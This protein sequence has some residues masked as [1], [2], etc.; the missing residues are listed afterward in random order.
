MKIRTLADIE[1]FEQVPA[2]ERW[3]GQNTY[4][5]IERSAHRHAE[6]PALQF[7]ASSDVG[8]E[9]TVIRYGELLKRIHQFAN[10]LYD[11]GLSPGA[12][13]SVIMPNQLETHFAL[14]GA[15]AFGIV[16]PINPMLESQGLRD[17]M[18]E[19]GSECLVVLGPTEA[20]NT[21]HKTMAI[22]DQIPSLKL[23]LRVDSASDRVADDATPGGIPVR[24]MMPAL[25]QASGSGLAFKREIAPESIAA[26]F[27]T[28]GT[29]GT[30]KLA[31]HTHANQVHLSSM[32]ADYFSFDEDTVAIAGLPLFHVNAFFNTGL[33][34]FACGGAAAMLTS[35]GFR[36][37]GVVSNLWRFVEKY[38]ARFF[39]TVP[40]V[41]SSLLE[42]PPGD[43]D[44]SSLNWI[45]C[46][47]APIAPQVF[48]DFQQA[49]GVN[50][51]EGYGLTEATLFS[52][53]NPEH[54]QKK[55]GSIGIRVPYQ[56][57]KCVILDDQGSY[58][59]DCEIDEA[60]VIVVR[61]PNVFPG[62]KQQEKNKAAFIDD[63]LITGDLARQDADGYFWMTG[64][65][66]DLIIRGGH[67]IDPKSIEDA[68]S[69]HPSVAL[70]GAIGQ[71]DSYAGEL[72]CAYVTLV[73]GAQDGAEDL[74]IYAKEKIAERAA[75]PV[76]IE[77]LEDMPVTAVGKIYKPDLRKLAIVRVYENSL[78]E[79]APTTKIEVIDDK[80]RGLV[81]VIECFDANDTTLE[82]IRNVLGQFAIDFELHRKL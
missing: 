78:R 38:R 56:A 25:E 44:I 16:G 42:N 81:A 82:K 75:V 76:H 58:I 71:P 51:I 12:V 6:R 60:G 14:W 19:S 49:T 69:E 22:V 46:G 39:V 29:T 37:R 52:A 40:T 45:M 73:A 20:D 17:I 31:Q 32:M 72:P 34:M 70:V 79:I 57:M 8:E 30:P 65:S 24:S 54:G 59:R 15:Q 66:K 62:Y 35:G 77:I 64:R 5:L 23:V 33:T 3:R 68:L 7:Q 1:G 27:H 43:T 13:T 41:V 21:W 9:P 55:V 74:T 47:A 67:N 63:W 80:R 4:E 61:G 10:T 11:A 18:N 48:R 26:Y 2:R 36:T 28:G 53:G 50:V